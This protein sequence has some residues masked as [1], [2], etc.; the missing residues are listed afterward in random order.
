MSRP[1]RHFWEVLLA[2]SCVGI[3]TF[4]AIFATDGHLGAVAAPAL[5]VALSYAVIR[6]PIRTVLMSLMF[7]VLVAESPQEMPADGLWQSPLYWLGALV[8]DNLNHTLSLPG[9][10]FA[11]VDVVALVLAAR[12]LHA[13]MDE[14]GPHGQDAH[15]VPRAMMGALLI[16]SATL[17]ALEAW[18]AVRGGAMGVSLWQIRQMVYVPI[19][20]FFLAEL[21]QRRRDFELIGRLVVWSALVKAFNG[22]FFYYFIVVPGGLAPEYI[23]TH[24]DAMHFVAAGVIVAARWLEAPTVG[25]LW[26]CAAVVPLMALGTFLNDRRLAYVGILG[27]AAIL[28]LLGPPSRSRRFLVKAGL[29]AL[30]LFALYCSAGWNSRLA[31]FRPVQSIRTMMETEDDTSS[32]SRDIE[33]YNLAQTLKSSPLL[34]VGLGHPYLEIVRGPPIESQFALYRYIPHNSVLWLLSAGGLIGFTALWSV[35]VVGAYLSARAFRHASEP[36]DRAAGLTCL[37]TILLYAIQA[38]G[39]MGTQSWATNLMLASAF[40]VAG[41]LAIRVGAWPAH[42]L[43]ASPNRLEER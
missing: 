33:N 43:M 36:L 28:F 37:C 29:L 8:L 21:L 19:F 38:Y 4:A 35:F 14:W 11:A 2:T 3:A 41:Q 30:P 34:G 10:G 31:M 26:A 27:C 40:V 12:I 17:L 7:L 9:L 16:F 6:L 42:S 1:P 13:R 39:D 32:Q 15:P 23:T 25:N 22:F 18:G 5:V 20:G 24:T